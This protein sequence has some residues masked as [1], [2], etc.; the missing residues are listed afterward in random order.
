MRE[1]S[2]DFET[3]YDTKQDYGIREMGAW[4]YVTDPRFDPYMISVCDGSECW[5]GH[6]KQFNWASLEGARVLSHNRY[7]DNLVYTEMVKRGLAAPVNFA[8]WQCTAN[9]TAFLCNRR[10]LAESCEH[11]LKV[12]VD[13]GVRDEM[14]GKR[15]RFLPE[16][17][18]GP[19]LEYAK[20]DALRCWQLWDKFSGQWPEFE[21]RLSNMTIEQ[22]WRGVQIDG[23]LLD[24]QLIV[25]HD[26][27]TRTEELLPW[28]EEG[29]K[30]AS[31]KAIAEQCRRVGIPCPPTKTDDAEGF[32]EWET[33]YGPRFPWIKAVS[34]RR[35]VNKMLSLLQT[36]KSRTRDD[37]TVPFAL[38]YFG[39]HTGRW[40]GDGGHNMQNPRKE[41]IFQNEHGLMETDKK[42]IFDA[43]AH[44]EVTHKWPEWVKNTIDE[45]A[46]YHARPGKRFVIADLSQIEP[47]VLNWLAGNFE[48]L[49]E[50]EKGTSVYEAHARATMSWTD[51][52][53]KKENK[54]LYALAKAR[55]LGLG[56]QC[57]WE[58]FIVV[59]R[60]MAGIDITENDPQ[61][62]EVASL[63]DVP[64]GIKHTV[65]EDGRVLVEGYGHF[66]RQCVSEFRASNPQIVALWRRL[67]DAFK[68][69]IG[70]DLEIELPSG[71]LMRYPRIRREV[72][73]VPDDKGKP[74][75]QYVYTA[76]IGGR[77]VP[78]YGGKLTENI[79]QATSRDVFGEHLLAV[80]DSGAAKVIFHAHD[81][82][83][84]ETDQECAKEAIV[85][86]MSTTPK[87]LPGCPLGAE[88]VESLHYVK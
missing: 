10:S 36:I 62:I 32:I 16:S 19:W 63:E 28:I 47:R 9:L 39:A 5:A 75:R 45:R 74:Q 8:E 22:G 58:K 76:D 55:V 29:A 49:A 59:A 3:F 72:R 81:E 18:R 50:V 38:K 86:I 64:K 78:F 53:L 25:A 51:G 1:I 52:N 7:F 23:D 83:I 33:T 67:D 13:K 88:A 42:R 40:S 31:P 27:L 61:H 82:G 70:R 48:M 26:L 57:A 17:R 43:L 60:V 2:V 80:E 73:V 84:Y 77:R 20:Q 35:S 30:P 21:R 56:Y 24:R 15:W 4:G 34:A 54:K 44:R 69:N 68:N 11:L 41:P 37:G 46:L 85:E 66:A 6:P 79:V 71:R 65:T 87:W 14:N 12:T